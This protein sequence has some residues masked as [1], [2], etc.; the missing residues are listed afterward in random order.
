M[1]RALLVS[2]FAFVLAACGGGE[3]ATNTAPAI[4]IEN[5]SLRLPAPGQTKGAAYF[6]VVN[7]G[8]ADILL[9][10]AT[11]FS[12]RVELHTHLHEDGMM[13][14]RQVES[15]DIGPEAVTH[16]KTGG[17]HVMI[18]DMNVPEGATHMPLTLTFAKSG[19]ID[20]NVTI[21]E[22]G[23]AASMG[24][25]NMKDMKTPDKHTGH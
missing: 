9:S 14:M 10:A 21:G 24:E 2:L 22:L 11:P 17:L 13:K 5:A 19:A 7:K 23:G 6:N 25:H 1:F 3:S 8:G 4:N 16:F 18:F 20:V 12:S 15:V